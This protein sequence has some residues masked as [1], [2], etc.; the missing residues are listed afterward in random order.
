MR[1]LEHGGTVVGNEINMGLSH[2]TGIGP[3]PA[4]WNNIQ[5]VADQTG[6]PVNLGYY[7]TEENYMQL[8]FESLFERL[9]GSL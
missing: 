5:S 9:L 6:I 1:V 3:C 7:D 8:R 4:C 2:V